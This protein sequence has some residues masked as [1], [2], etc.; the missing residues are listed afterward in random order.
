MVKLLFQNIIL[1]PY[2]LDLSFHV[3]YISFIFGLIKHKAKLGPAN[4]WAQK[5]CTHYTLS[6]DMFAVQCFTSEGN[7]LCSCSKHPMAG[8]K[9]FEWERHVINQIGIAAHILRRFPLEGLQGIALRNY[10]E[11]IFKSCFQFWSSYVIIW[12]WGT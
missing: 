2:F 9:A 6:N 5:S 11:F 3:A 7:N 12:P 8:R 4:I 10:S 1:R